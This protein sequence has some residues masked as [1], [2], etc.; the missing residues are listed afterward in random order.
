MIEALVIVAVA[1]TGLG[2]VLFRMPGWKSSLALY[3]AYLAGFYLLTNQPTLLVDACGTEC[4]AQ[5]A[6]DILTRMYVGV[7][8]FGLIVLG[9]IRFLAFLNFGPTTKQ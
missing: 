3:T 5:A 8:W 1:M 7:A 6:G 4:N 2:F 9:V